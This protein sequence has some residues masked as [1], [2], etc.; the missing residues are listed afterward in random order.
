MVHFRTSGQD[1]PAFYINL[2]HL[3]TQPHQN[4]NY[5]VEQPLLKQSFAKDFLSTYEETR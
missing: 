4:Y 2:A 3:L 5:I 1:G